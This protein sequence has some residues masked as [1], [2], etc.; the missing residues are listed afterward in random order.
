MSFAVTRFNAAFSDGSNGVL[1]M[2]VSQG[3]VSVGCLFQPHLPSHH[4]QSPAPRRPGTGNPQ[5]P[6]GG[7]GRPSRFPRK[8]GPGG[9]CDRMRGEAPSPAARDF[10][11]PR[12]A[13]G[14]VTP[15]WVH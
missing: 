10:P 14:G 6:G 7:G 3:D 1:G 4:F 12:H 5:G 13:S 9:S 15:T 8:E 2:G 11:K